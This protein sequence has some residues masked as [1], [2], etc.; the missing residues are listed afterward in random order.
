MKPN[1]F[2]FIVDTLKQGQL[3]GYGA[4]GEPT[5]FLERTLQRGT[6]FQ[7]F[8]PAGGTT[9]VSVNAFCNGFFGGTSGLN[10]QHCHDRFA[11]S[12]VLTLADV[13]SSNGYRTVAMTQGDISLQ[14][15]GFD[16]VW[17]RQ[18]RFTA[19]W[20]R[21]RVLGGNQPVFAYLH[22]YGLHDPAFGHPELM[23]PANYRRHLADLDAEI[24]EV[25]QTLVGPQDVVVVASDHGCRLRKTLD[26]AWRFYDEEEPTA[27]TFLSEETIG[28]VCSLIGPRYF[29]VVGVKSL[30]RGI[31]IFPTLCDGLALPRPAVQ[32]RSLWPALQ[33]REPW[34]RL[35]ACI[36]TGGLPLADGQAACRCLRTDH[37]KYIWDATHG[38]SLYD[39]R[40]DPGEE[41][42]LIGS[43]HRQEDVMRNLLAR[44]MA[45]NRQGTEPFYRPTAELCRR[46]RAARKP[47]AEVNRGSRIFAFTGLID[48]TT[49]AHLAAEIARHLPRWR[50]NNERIVLYSASAHARA[51]LAAA[52]PD[53]RRF[54]VGII[55]SNAGSDTGSLSGIPIRPV[56]SLTTDLQPTQVLVA[57]HHY[58]PDMYI[59]LRN[60]CPVP[61]PVFSIYH[62][63][64][65]INPWW[66]R[67]TS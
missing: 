11:S 59:Q 8:F 28:G 24:Q 4:P 54:I 55:D 30:V 52:G 1:V 31:D 9:R 41:R 61:L 27:G 22:F 57:H 33:G 44:Q 47:M 16:E 42:N 62:L 17:T 25:W 26:P 39:L 19:A 14:P 35:N 43:G 67:T 36:E 58:A 13:F 60:T 23:T 63:D 40:D 20:L 66:D 6:C 18:E 2:V 46:M 34:P 37:W 12:P 49:R 15:A 65:L 56:A 10:H 64:Q 38:E 32:G 50:E 21:D 5:G 3:R 7:N 53:G 48:E 45:E 29:P 51:F